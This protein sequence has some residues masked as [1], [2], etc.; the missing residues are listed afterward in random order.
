MSLYELVD[1]QTNSLRKAAKPSF[2]DRSVERVIR[3]VSD[4]YLLRLGELRQE[5]FLDP[6]GDQQH[7]IRVRQD[8]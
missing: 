1:F 6:N 8:H 3:R 2:G 5:L 4:I 7:Q